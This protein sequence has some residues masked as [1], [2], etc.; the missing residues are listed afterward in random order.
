METVEQTLRNDVNRLHF[1]AKRSIH[2]SQCMSAKNKFYIDKRI[3]MTKLLEAKKQ[4]KVQWKEKLQDVKS[5]L[6]QQERENETLVQ[7]KKV[8]EMKL[9]NQAKLIKRA[10]EKRKRMEI[11]MRQEMNEMVQYN[12][13]L[14]EKLETKILKTKR[15]KASEHLKLQRQIEQIEAI[16]NPT[17]PPPPTVPSVSN[18]II[19][20]PVNLQ[21]KTQIER[22]AVSLQS[23]SI[24]PEPVHLQE[25]TDES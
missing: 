19:A 14:Q 5:A 10:I 21:F 13:T 17:V 18:Q 24:E 1:E 6:K 9:E 2:Y 16:R 3:E 7:E 4:E 15:P 8:L 25:A 12:Q 23:I 20:H 22:I 11:Q